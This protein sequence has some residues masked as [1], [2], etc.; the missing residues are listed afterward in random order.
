M[1]K[2]NIKLIGMILA[3][4]AVAAAVQRHVLTV[5]VVGGYLPR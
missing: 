3:T 4:Y 2:A 5:P 1:S